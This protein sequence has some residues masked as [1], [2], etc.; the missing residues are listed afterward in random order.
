MKRNINF[1]LLGVLILS[2]VLIIISTSLRFITGG[3]VPYDYGITIDAGSSKTKFV[4]YDWLSAKTNETGFVNEL[5]T[6][7]LEISIDEFANDQT[8][9]VKPLL[10]T[11]YQITRKVEYTRSS[12]NIPIYLGATAGMRL[13]KA[14]NND[15]SD[16][17]LREIRSSF[18]Q[19]TGSQRRFQ[20]ENVEI[21]SGEK[22]G[23]YCWISTNYLMGYVPPEHRPING[24]VGILDMGGASAQIAFQ[25]FCRE[26]GGCRM[27]K[28]RTN[29]VANE[30][31]KLFGIEYDVYSYSNLCF[32]NDDARRRYQYVVIINSNSRSN[33]VLDPC[34]HSGQLDRTISKNQILEDVCTANEKIKNDLRYD[35]YVFRAKPDIKRCQEY[36]KMLVSPDFVNKHFP[37]NGDEINFKIIEEAPPADMPFYALATYFYT[38][39]QLRT[40]KTMRFEDEDELR[41]EID[42]YC[43]RSWADIVKNGNNNKIDYLHN[44][45][46]SLNYMFMNLKFVYK[47]SGKHFNKIEFRDKLNGHDLGWSL[48]YML[49]ATNSIPQGGPEDPILNTSQFMS[50]SLLGVVLFLGVLF[51][52][53]KS[54]FSK[55]NDIS[56][57]DSSGKVQF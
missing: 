34:T 12:F 44:Y 32:G 56:Y 6:Q 37:S 51:V 8:D 31:T 25:T 46:F 15:Y 7:K 48:G 10:T 16:K 52:F 5:A 38:T 4:L 33:E 19:F 9:L 13:L 24:T 49:Q 50:I 54:K 28:E 21:I 42:N 30:Q 1:I 41:K 26:I 27:E 2:V 29:L 43:S 40:N 18:I 35:S 45:C 17:I 14:S 57:S 55:G 22:E 20:V 36:T 47:F 53:L 23:L 11:L 39:S 3:R